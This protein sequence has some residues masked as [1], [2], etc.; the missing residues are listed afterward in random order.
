MSD[1]LCPVIAAPRAARRRCRPTPGEDRLPGHVSA[2]QHRPRRADP[3]WRTS[4]ARAIGP[5]RTIGSRSTIAP[6]GG[7]GARRPRP[8]AGR[9]RGGRWPRAAR[10]RARA[11]WR[12][13]RTVQAGRPT[14]ASSGAG[15][16]P[17]AAAG[18]CA[19]LAPQS[20]TSQPTTGKAAAQ[21]RVTCRRAVA[22]RVSSG[23]RCRRRNRR[24]EVGVQ[25]EHPQAGD[26]DAIGFER[27]A[28]SSHRRPP[29]LPSPAES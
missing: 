3:S 19:V 15:S 13:A 27:Q 18:R 8:Q 12:P 21:K 16:V 17:A 26:A 4:D 14:A 5:S 10:R 24:E 25:G 9:T 11:R 23:G 28:G 20:G 1:S 2:A 7:R 6:S 22:G 29:L